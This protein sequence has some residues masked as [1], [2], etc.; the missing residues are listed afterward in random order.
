MNT[1][2][3]K[4]KTKKGRSF[5]LWWSRPLWRL[6]SHKPN[7]VVHAMCFSPVHRWPS[8]PT[9]ALDLFYWNYCIE[10]YWQ[11]RTPTILYK[12]CAFRR[13]SA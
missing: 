9:L 11:H 8:N 5:A 3:K 4:N 1:E 7:P 13:T 10:Y 2:K 12:P 6:D